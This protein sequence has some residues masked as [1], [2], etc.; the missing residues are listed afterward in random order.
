MRD[1]QLRNE[2]RTSCNGRY[3][4]HVGVELSG[5]QRVAVPSDFAP[6]RPSIPLVW[7][8]CFLCLPNYTFNLSEVV[9]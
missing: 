6:P 1:Y 3:A 2:V 4:V 8:Y 9:N 7:A 5:K